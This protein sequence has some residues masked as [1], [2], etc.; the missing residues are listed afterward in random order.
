MTKRYPIPLFEKSILLDIL[1]SMGVYSKKSLE[2]LREKIDLVEV[3]SSYVPLKSTGGAYKGLCPFHDEKTPSFGI[4]KGESHYHCFGC[5]AHGEETRNGWE[6]GLEPGKAF[7]TLERSK[8]RG[9]LATDI[10]PC[11]TVDDH[12][13]VKTG[14]LDVL[15]KPTLAIGLIHSAL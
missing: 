15:A 1:M 7:P 9:L 2:L 14:P 4:Q 12:V 8:E 5:G 3:V 11:P 13:Q 6:G 10:R